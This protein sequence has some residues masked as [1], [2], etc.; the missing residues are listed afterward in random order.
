MEWIQGMREGKESE[1][2]HWIL[3]WASKRTK[4]PFIPVVD[5]VGEDTLGRDQK[6][7]GHVK[8]Q[9]SPRHPVK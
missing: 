3:E 2:T 5:T 6:F 9:V 8:F 7:S 1:M 4:V